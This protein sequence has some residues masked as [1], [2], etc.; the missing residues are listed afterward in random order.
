M[1][2]IVVQWALVLLLLISVG[3]QS[4]SGLLDPDRITPGERVFEY[5]QVQ[6]DSSRTFGTIYECIN[7]NTD[8]DVIEIIY[9]Q[10]LPNRTII[11]SIIA[12][13]QTM[14]PVRYRS[15]VDGI[16]DIRVEYSVPGDTRI[17]I[18][19]NMQ[20]QNI[21]TVMSVETNDAMYDYHW[22]NVLLYALNPPKVE[23]DSVDI[24]VFTYRDKKTN[25][26][27]RYAGEEILTTEG[28]EHRTRVWKET[29]S[30]SG[31]ERTHW[32]DYRTNRLVRS[33]AQLPN[34]VIFWIK[35]KKLQG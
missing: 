6:G 22:P 26:S 20:S 2:T 23:G 1:K 31:I 10:E 27:I 30:R 3:C 12:D 29:D 17:H 35:R 33:K 16:Q 34:G 14:F 28:E 9:L 24:Q 8:E 21:D 18:K 15:F 32:I 13:R 4:Q 5:E 11:D 7:H 25:Q 19:K